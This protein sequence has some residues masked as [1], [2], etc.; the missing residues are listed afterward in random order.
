MLAEEERRVLFWNIEE[1]GIRIERK[2]KFT[3][4]DVALLR[5]LMK[6]FGP[7]YY[8]N[9]G[10]LAKSS[11]MYKDKQI[12]GWVIK[13]CLQQLNPTLVKAPN[14]YKALHQRVLL[15]RRY[16]GCNDAFL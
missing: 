4:D 15:L 5:L 8:N 10:R 2:R 16:E 3:D 11:E 7:M 14:F 13:S 1:N 6:S 9:R 12:I